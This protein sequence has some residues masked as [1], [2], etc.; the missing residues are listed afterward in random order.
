MFFIISMFDVFASECIF[1]FLLLEH[2]SIQAVNLCM[3]LIIL[4]NDAFL[5]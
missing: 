3:M 4:L 2:E 5:H 1:V